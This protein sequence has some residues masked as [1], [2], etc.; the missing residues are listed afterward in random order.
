MYYGY[1]NFFLYN[2]SIQ[3]YTRGEFL[4]TPY[5]IGNNS[6]LINIQWVGVTSQNTSIKFQI[7]T[8]MNLSKINNK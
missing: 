5:N 6:K 8:S 1:G 7:R 3:D 2:Y 4:S